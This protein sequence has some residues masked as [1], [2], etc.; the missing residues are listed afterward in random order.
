MYFFDEDFADSFRLFF[1]LLA[2]GFNRVGLNCVILF[3]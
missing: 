3:I 2:V 1:S